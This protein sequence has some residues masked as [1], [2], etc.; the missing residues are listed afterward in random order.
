MSESETENLFVRWVGNPWFWALWVVLIA[1]M[2][3]SRAFMAEVPEPPPVIAIVPEFEYTDQH[4]EAF[5]TDRLA[6]KVWVANFIFTRC[7][8]IC[9]IFTDKMYEVQHR[10]KNLGDLFHL[11]SFSVDPEYDTP[12]VLKAYADKH[13]VSSRMWS[14]LTGPIDEVKDTVVNGMKIT[15][16]EREDPEQV[17]SLLHGSHF[18]LVD[19]FR[20]IRGFYDA[21]DADAVD[22]MLM[23]VKILVNVKGAQ[24]PMDASHFATQGTT[25]SQEQGATAPSSGEGEPT[26]EEGEP[27]ADEAEAS[28]EAVLE[29]PVDE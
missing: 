9:P 8:T 20:Q 22:R 19:A 29:A 7:T 21:N 10:G 13:R 26:N 24:V 11:V 14:F 12:E 28:G 23:D 2:P 25:G 27:A 15:M 1:S 18:V 6:G 5:G 4:G 17:Q 16:E 3:L